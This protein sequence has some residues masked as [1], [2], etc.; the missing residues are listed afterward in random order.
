MHMRVDQ[1]GHDRTITDV[2]YPQ[3][4]IQLHLRHLPYSSDA[5]LVNDHDSIAYHRPAG[6]I[7]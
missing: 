7:E 1:S 2:N 6:A 5:C 3:A 4:G